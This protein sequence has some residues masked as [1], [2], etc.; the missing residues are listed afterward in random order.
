MAD[1]ATH[2]DEAFEKRK[3][4]IGIRMTL[5]YS[6]VYAGFVVL[7]VFRPTW[8]GAR[9]VFGLNVA[10][11]YGLGLILIAIAFALIYNHL[12]RVPSDRSTTR[13]GA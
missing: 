5:L 3:S 6:V 13:K 2:M 12:C 1:G 8:M 10:V 11:S 4:R 7:S 9:A